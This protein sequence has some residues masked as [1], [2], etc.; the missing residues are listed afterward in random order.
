VVSRYDPL[1]G[2]IDP[3]IDYSFADHGT[4]V[5]GIIAAKND[6]KGV[7]GLAYNAKIMDIPIFQPGFIGTFSVADGIVW[8][9][10][11]GA[12]VLSNSWGGGAYSQ[13]LKA[14]FDYALANGVVVV[15]A[16]GNDGEALWNYPA[17]YP[18][19]IA[20][21]ASNPHN[22]KADFSTTGGWLSVVAPGEGVLSSVPTW[23]IQD[24]SGSPLLYDYWAGT[25][26]STPFVSALSA[27]VREGHPTA[28]TYQVK[29]IMEQ[30]ALDIEA[31]GFD[32]KSGY[33][34]IQADR[35]VVAPVPSDGAALRIHV[36][37]KSSPDLWGEYW[38]TIM[39]DVI[40]RRNG[41]DIYRGQT[42][43]EGWWVLGY[44]TGDYYPGWG[45]GF[46]PSIE[47]GTYQILVGGDD[48]TWL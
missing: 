10:D 39:M 32:T 11:N 20:V 36:V 40:L 14:A 5:A 35:A 26:M 43:L 34:L 3:T 31:T 8:A 2:G 13:V 18:G 24:G 15:A 41:V 33:G 21:G 44:P 4:H 37:T 16:A 38:P 48:C 46:F 25:S 12:D 1:V 9:V 19:V 28:T 29:R 47:P 22:K 23:V 17:A 27:M 30:T 42:D 45:L 6:S 7:V